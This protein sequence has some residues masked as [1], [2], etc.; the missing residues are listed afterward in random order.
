MRS[1]KGGS[2]PFFYF[3]LLFFFPP[4][5]S[6]PV[7]RPGREEEV[8]QNLNEV[9]KVGRVRDNRQRKWERRADRN[10]ISGKMEQKT[11]QKRAGEARD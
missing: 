7:E 2:F 8:E 10:I 3:F 9:G 5:A 6:P 11:R 4:L 1:R